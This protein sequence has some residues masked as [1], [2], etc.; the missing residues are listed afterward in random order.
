[1]VQ[2]YKQRLEGEN[3]EQVTHFLYLGGSI[4]ERAYGGATQD[5]NRSECIEKSR[6][7]WA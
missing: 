4:S 1:M 5:T 3:I 7:K 6:G 2:V